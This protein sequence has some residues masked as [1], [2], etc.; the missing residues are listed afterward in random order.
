MRQPTGEFA[1]WSAVPVVDLRS[2]GR[3]EGDDGRR[4]QQQKKGGSIQGDSD[5]ESKAQPDTG[6]RGR[7]TVSGATV[8]AIDTE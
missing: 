1:K 7:D 2:S 8:V 6:G 3:K 4:R 5:E